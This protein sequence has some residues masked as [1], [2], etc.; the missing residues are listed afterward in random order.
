MKLMDLI[1]VLGSGEEIRIATD[2]GQQWLVADK[3]IHIDDS[4]KKNDF[5]KD[6]S[7][8]EVINVYT[9]EARSGDYCQ[10]LEPAVCIILEGN[11]NGTI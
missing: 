3:V 4:I 6:L 9:S 7:Q 2:G 8:R 5:M 1:N 10:A 11:E